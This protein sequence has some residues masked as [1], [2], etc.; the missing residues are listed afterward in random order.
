MYKYTVS[1]HI[2][3]SV[4]EHILSPYHSSLKANPPQTPGERTEIQNE[5]QNF[6]FKIDFYTVEVLI[7]EHKIGMG[8]AV[9]GEAADG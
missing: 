3:K 9:L 8:I 6:P 2:F 4:A 7:E 5:I 1:K